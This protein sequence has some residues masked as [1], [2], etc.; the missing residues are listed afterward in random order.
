LLIFILTSDVTGD[1]T[2]LDRRGGLAGGGVPAL[3]GD[4]LSFVGDE[5]S[6][7]AN[8]LIRTARIL[9]HNLLLYEYV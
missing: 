1:R 5:L 6:D 4:V 7:M 3:S 2:A 8:D 9:I